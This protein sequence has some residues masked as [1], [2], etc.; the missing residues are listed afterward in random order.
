MKLEK[1]LLNKIK[2][3]EKEIGILKSDL[4]KSNDDKRRLM[5]RIIM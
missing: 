2:R 4:K 5:K 3:L 1:Q